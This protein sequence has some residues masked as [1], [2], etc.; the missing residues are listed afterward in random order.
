MAGTWE[1]LPKDRDPEAGDGFIGWDS[2]AD[3]EV[4]FYIGT[5]EFRIP[6]NGMINGKFLQ[7]ANNLSDLDDAPTARTNLGI[8]AL[9]TPY[10]NTDSSLSAGNVKL[11]I[12]ELDSQANQPE[13]INVSYDNTSSSS[14]EGKNVHDALDY[15]GEIRYTLPERIGSGI[16]IPVGSGSA[17]ICTF[18]NNT[19]VA[20]DDDLYLTVFEWSEN[21]KEFSQIGNSLS[22]STET[23]GSGDISKINDT[24]IAFADGIEESI[25][26]YQWDGS[27]NFSLIGNVFD[28]SSFSLSEPRI[29]YISDNFLALFDRSNNELMT[30]EWDGSSLSVFGNSLS[31]PT[32]RNDI[33]TLSENTIVLWK[34]DSSSTF[35]ET[36]N[37][38]GND[39]NIVGNTLNLGFSGGVSDFL[40]GKFDVNT[41]FVYEGGQDFFSA[42]F[43]DGQ[44]WSQISQNMSSI[45]SMGDLAFLSNGRIA[46]IEYWN[47]GIQC[48]GL[49][50]YFKNLEYNPYD[51]PSYQI[52]AWCDLKGNDGSGNAVIKGQGNIASVTRTGTG[53]YDV[54]FEVPMP[55]SSYSVT[56]STSENS[57]GTTSR[58]DTV[59]FKGYTSNGFSVE[60]WHNDD[61]HGDNEIINFQVVR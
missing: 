32:D 15:I 48:Y 53:T 40:I 41:V 36:Y 10:D 34:E 6:T 13:A 57:T 3:E 4:S 17:T 12:D 19:I 29:T 45:T 47:N 14:L 38:D 61:N 37:W 52:R 21:N 43:W 22:T 20:Y 2:S 50:S 11:A 51:L 1:I 44:D 59:A 23:S 49:K 46:D 5:T 55:D 60:V 54:T 24:I 30:L 16:S 56:G 26:A 8:N 31:I 33:C 39:W 27:S 7:V 58:A 18:L 25:F 42:F 35:L 9:N 28:T